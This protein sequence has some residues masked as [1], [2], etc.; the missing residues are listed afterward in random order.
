MKGGIIYVCRIYVNNAWYI[1]MHDS[2]MYIRND[3]RE[4]R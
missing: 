2:N 3:M 1:N 4:D